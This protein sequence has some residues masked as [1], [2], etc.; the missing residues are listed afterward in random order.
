MP[1]KSGSSRETISSN[2]RE[3]IESGHPQKQAVAAALSKSREDKLKAF[4][5][6]ID[7]CMDAVE[8]LNRRIDAYTARRADA[9][10][11]VKILGYT[12][13]EGTKKHA[14]LLQRKK[15][16]EDLERSEIRPP[17]WNRED[18]FHEQPTQDIKDSRDDDR[19]V[20]GG[21]GHRLPP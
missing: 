17:T 19:R 10:K 2:I 20:I 11:E 1:L 6:A 16:V 15:Q 3:M 13:K 7:A 8:G 12:V 14:E 9:G 21:I 5:D 18:E 4:S